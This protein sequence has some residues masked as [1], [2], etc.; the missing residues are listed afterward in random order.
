MSSENGF[1]NSLIQTGTY[2]VDLTSVCV[3]VFIVCN[4]IKLRVCASVVIQPIILDVRLFI[5][6]MIQP[7]PFPRRP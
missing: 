3:C 4:D 1:R 2:Y 5:A 6:R 7:V